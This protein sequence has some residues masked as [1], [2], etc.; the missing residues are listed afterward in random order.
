M[1]CIADCHSQCTSSLL[2]VSPLCS[3]SPY[4][5]SSLCSTTNPLIGLSH[6]SILHHAGLRPSVYRPHACTIFLLHHQNRA[7]LLSNAACICECVLAAA[8][9][10]LVARPTELTAD[11]ARRHRKVRR[12]EQALP[13]HYCAP[14]HPSKLVCLKGGPAKREERIRGLF[15]CVFLFAGMFML[16][17]HLRLFHIF[18]E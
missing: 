10:V 18:L 1:S 17:R 6:T 13:S 11:V 7:L 16:I 12:N 8:E 9:T 2:L 4:V 5:L 14:H 15:V 3:D